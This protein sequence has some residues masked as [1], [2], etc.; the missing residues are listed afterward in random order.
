[1]PTSS[2]AHR[3][4]WSKASVRSAKKPRRA[5]SRSTKRSR[6]SRAQ[7]EQGHMEWISAIG[8][9]GLRPAPLWGRVGEGVM[10]RGNNR[11]TCEGKP[12][13]PHPNPSPQGGGERTE[14]A[15]LM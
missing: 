9:L 3:R 10:Q 2:P 13:Y 14:Y 12:H 5:A 8:E 6:A 1:M 15:A 11:A 7:R 4:T